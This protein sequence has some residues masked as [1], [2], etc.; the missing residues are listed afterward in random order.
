MCS[1]GIIHV[2]SW[3]FF[4]EK[5]RW[6]VIETALLQPI[7]T[8]EEFEKAV[9]TY[10]PKFVGKWSFGGLH[11]LFDEVRSLKSPKLPFST[12]ILFFH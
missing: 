11:D 1:N 4:K 8:I 12:Q 5:Q 3:T 10:N 2:F 6:D 7:R 9:L